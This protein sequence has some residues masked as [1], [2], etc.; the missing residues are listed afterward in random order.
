[1]LVDP[2]R[3]PQNLPGERGDSPSLFPPS[4]QPHQ[5]GTRAIP[6]QVHLYVDARGTGPCVPSRSQRRGTFKKERTERKIGERQF[7]A[8]AIRLDSEAGTEDKEL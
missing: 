4:Q 8:K 6:D 5:D 3:R 2:A 7:S 1:M